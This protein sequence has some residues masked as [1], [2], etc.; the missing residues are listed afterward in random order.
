MTDIEILQKLKTHDEG[1][2][3]ALIDRYAGYV[4]TIICNLARSSLPVEDVEELSADV[5]FSIWKAAARLR[6]DLPL[7]PYLAAAARNATASR[8]RRQRLPTLPLGDELVLPDPAAGPVELAELREYRQLLRAALDSIGEPDREIFL[9]RYCF[10]EQLVAIANR[11]GLPPQT[12]KT[13]L[14]RCRQKLQQML[15]ERGYKLEED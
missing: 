5:F 11:L 13:K 4:S 1:G 9:R 12:A 6:T 2:Y 7:K 15:N 8:L 14:R 10:G 3:T